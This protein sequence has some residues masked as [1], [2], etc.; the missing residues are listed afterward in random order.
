MRTFL[1]SALLLVFSAFTFAGAAEPDKA[2]HTD[3]IYPTVRISWN[4]Q[5]IGSGVVVRSEK[6]G[7][8]YRNVVLTCDHVADSDAE[9][10]V[11]V[12]TYKDWSTF[13]GWSSYPAK[14]Y[15]GH[16]E[17]DLAVIV[18]VTAKP[19]PVANF[20]FDEKLY[21]GTT[22]SNLGCGM[23]DE[24]RL[25]FGV[26]TSMRGIMRGS[27]YKPYRTNLKLIGGDSGGPVFRDGKLIGIA[28]AIKI[29]N[30]K[31]VPQIL[32]HISFVI[33]IEQLKLWDEDEKKC[34]E[35]VYKRTRPLPA[36]P[37]DMLRVRPLE[38]VDNE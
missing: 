19:M 18:F 35:F 3:C 1:L 26:V 30:F 25:D 37:Y 36:L 9:Y 12:P 24:P 5:G 20:G 32:P 6:Y 14:R 33:P 22:I 11:D 13:D 2:L 10:S 15:D 17:R 29:T 34:L 21:I 38:I 27:K 16:S 8:H 28:Q 7:S 23:N 4:N 31:G